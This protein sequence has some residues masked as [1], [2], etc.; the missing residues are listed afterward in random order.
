[1]ME[2]TSTESRTILAIEALK[3]DPNLK[4]DSASKIALSFKLVPVRFGGTIEA[5]KRIRTP[6]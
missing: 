6:A 2:S 4:A 3:K 5:M 1:M